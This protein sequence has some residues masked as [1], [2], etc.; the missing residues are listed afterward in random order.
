MS[1]SEAGAQTG[2]LIEVEDLWKTYQ[3]GDVEVTALRGV[4]LRVEAG[5]FVV[6]GQKIAEA[7]SAGAS[8]GPHLHFEVWGSGFYQLADPWAGSCGPNFD[9]PRWAFDPPWEEP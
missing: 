3:L 6:Q 8:S 2:A 5:E 7:A 1:A 4:T 9:N